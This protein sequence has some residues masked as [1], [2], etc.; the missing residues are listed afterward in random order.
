VANDKFLVRKTHD[1][2]NTK[3]HTVGKKTSTI[4]IIQ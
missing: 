3:N 1:F 2:S 4:Y